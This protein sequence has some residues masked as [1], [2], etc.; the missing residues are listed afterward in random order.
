[1]NLT[2]VRSGNKEH[3]VFTPEESQKIS[4]AIVMQINMLAG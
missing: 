4:N 3:Q 1:M 2:P